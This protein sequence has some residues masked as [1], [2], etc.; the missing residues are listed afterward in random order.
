[1]FSQG[2]ISYKQ[3][4]KTRFC[5]MKCF[6]A[7]SVARSCLNCAKEFEV[8]TYSVKNGRGK[9]CSKKCKGMGWNSKGENSPSWKG[10]K[11]G[12]FGLHYRISNLLGKPNFCEL[13]KRTD[14]SRYEWANVSK[15]YKSDLSD[16]IRLCTSCHQKYDKTGVKSWVT[17]RERYGQL[18]H[19]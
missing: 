1:M 6:K 11:V 16:W 19:V 10:D 5:S 4:E 17:R 13:C 3:W 8:P 2:K 18:G 12:Y 15:E 9:Y 14:K 7:I